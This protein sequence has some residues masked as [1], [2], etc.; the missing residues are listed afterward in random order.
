LA[1]VGQTRKKKKKKKRRR[2]R[3]RKDMKKTMGERSTLATARIGTK[4][5]GA[6][7]LEEW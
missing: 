4:K 7:R 3:R 2:R 6:S 5:M 1:V